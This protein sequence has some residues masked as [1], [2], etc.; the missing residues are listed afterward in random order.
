MSTPSY[1]DSES[2]TQNDG[3][4]SSR[5]PAP[6]PDGPY[7]AVRHA[8][9]VDTE[10]EPEE[11]PSEAEEVT[12]AMALSDSAFHKRYR[13]SYE[14]PS[15]SSSTALPILKR[16]RE[17][18]D[19]EGH[20]SDDE[21]RGLEGEGLGLEEEEA[22]PEGQQQAVPVVDTAA[23]KPLGLGYGTARCRA[24]ESIEEITPSTYEIG[25]SSRSIPE[26]QGAD[27]LELHG[28]ILHDHTQCLDALPPTLVADIAKDVRE[29]YTRALWR[30][31][32][33]LEAWAGHVDTRLV[34]T[35]RDRYDDHRLIH[36]MLVQQ[37]AMQR[38]LQEM[39]G[40]V[41]ALEQERDRRE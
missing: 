35:S 32:L 31:V 21:G 6:L 25:Q 28:S 4:Q 22:A 1:V 15:S 12:E 24:L 36:D 9:L 38:E 19:D 8:R 29:L 11:A 30:P 18:S 20:G 23:S 41:T 14:T 27:R 13:S 2:I 10:S 7:V 37:A 34:D 39:R 33:A 5:V 40:R 3:A 17:G 26:Q 16:E